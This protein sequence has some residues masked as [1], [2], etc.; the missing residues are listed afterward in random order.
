MVKELTQDEYDYFMGN[1]I[2]G[3]T[4]FSKEEL[5]KMIE[6]YNRV[7]NANEKPTSC[8]RCLARIAESIV[9]L[10]KNSPYYRIN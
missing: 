1:K 10:V 9:Y 8:G 3:K 4:N 7:Y 6:V 2:I 5:Y